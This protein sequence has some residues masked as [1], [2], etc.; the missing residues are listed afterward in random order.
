MASFKDFYPNEQNITP[1][2]KDYGEEF[3]TRISKKGVGDKLFEIV[4]TYLYPVIPMF[5]YFEKRWGI[6]VAAVSLVLSILPFFLGCVLYLS[7]SAH[8]TGRG[9]FMGL[10]V[11]L[12]SILL[13]RG[14]QGIVY[15]LLI[16]NLLIVYTTGYY[17]LSKEKKNR[18]G[19]K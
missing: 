6:K 5:N 10:L 11:M 3:R 7:Y 13:T 14:N 8:L 2:N 19:T 1:I 16:S 12:V 15:F 18:R 9:N 4:I 17:Q